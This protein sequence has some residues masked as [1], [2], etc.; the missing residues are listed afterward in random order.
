MADTREVQIAIWTKMR[1]AGKL[2][3]V[4]TN[5]LFGG[6]IMA[7]AMMAVA[8]LKTGTIQVTIEAMVAFVIGAAYGAFGARAEWKKYE[9]IY[10]D[11]SH[12][13]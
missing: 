4:L 13:Q 3:H 9:S 10:P 11:I 6:V 7:I 1:R 5:G 12:G 8:W 2:R